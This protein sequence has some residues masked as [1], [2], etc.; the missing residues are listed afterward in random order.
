[1]L[2]DY[3]ASSAKTKAKP[4]HQL[5]LCI[6]GPAALPGVFMSLSKLLLCTKR[7]SLQLNLFWCLTLMTFLSPGLFLFHED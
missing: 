4:P 7:G 3:G 5:W 1:M 2:L 6:Q